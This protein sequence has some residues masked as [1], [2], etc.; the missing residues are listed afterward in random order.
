MTDLFYPD[1]SWLVTWTEF[2]NAVVQN[3]YPAPTQDQYYSFVS[4]LTTQ[5]GITSKRE[6]AMFLAQIMWESDGLR[7]KREYACLV[8]GC[9]G[10]YGSTQYSQSYYGRGYIQLVNKSCLNP[11]FSNLLWN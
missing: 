8:T 11:F 3:G 9:P 5:G 2:T 10:T 1:A 7:A 4:Q 6:A